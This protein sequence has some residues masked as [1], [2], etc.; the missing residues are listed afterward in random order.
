MGSTIK[1]IQLGITFIILCVSNFSSAQL[2]ITPLNSIPDLVNTYFKR[3]GDQISNFVFSGDSNKGIAEF[4]EPSG[5]L[6]IWSGII[7]ST[8][9]VQDA[10]GPNNFYN[11]GSGGSF[12]TGQVGGGSSP[13]LNSLDT[14]ISFQVQQLQFDIIPASSILIFEYVFAS[15]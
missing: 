15:D 11:A 5:N 9:P 12:G 2:S 6:E 7:M 1:N 14:T 3:T 10:L 8:G 13:L 4:H